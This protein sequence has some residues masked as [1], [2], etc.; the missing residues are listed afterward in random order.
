MDSSTSSKASICQPCYEKNIETRLVP[1]TKDPEHFMICPYCNN[2][3]DKKVM[4]FESETQ[5]LGYK[6][7]HGPV[8]FEV[9]NPSR[10]RSRKNRPE[11]DF[12]IPKFGQQ[13][14]LDLKQM[15][16]DGAIILSIKDEN[17][18]STEEY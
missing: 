15:V 1:Y 6:G 10:S 9:A 5:P 18:D 11:P 17:V 16:V 14:D 7:G 4:R 13:E 3:V 2:I 12:D 8:S